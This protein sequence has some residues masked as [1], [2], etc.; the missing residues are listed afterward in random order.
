MG[1]GLCGVVKI[2]RGDLYRTQKTQ[3]DLF[4]LNITSNSKLLYITNEATV[5]VQCS[6][7]EDNNHKRR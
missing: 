2:I 5:K 4:T 3:N 7:T 1:G 6:K